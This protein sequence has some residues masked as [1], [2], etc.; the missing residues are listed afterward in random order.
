L[1]NKSDDLT[2]IVRIVKIY[3]LTSMI[4]VHILN[5]MHSHETV[6]RYGFVRCTIPVT[7]Q[8]IIAVYEPV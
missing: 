4:R 6:K 1:V 8:V 2:K 5:C 3:E 7:F